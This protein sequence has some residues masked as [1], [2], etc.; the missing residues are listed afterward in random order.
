M[1]AARSQAVRLR[2]AR[3]A[4]GFDTAADAIERFGWKQSTYLAHE[5]GQNGIRPGPA[6]DYGKAYKVSSAWILTG[7]GRGPTLEAQVIEAPPTNPGIV[8]F[9][10]AAYTAIGRYDAAFSAGPG[11]LV[12]PNPVPL[13]YYL[14]ETQWLHA[15]T[16]AAPA[17]LAIVRVAGDSMVNTLHDG[18]WVLIDRTQRSISREGIYAIQVLD[19][20]WV[21]RLSL[22]LKEKLVRVIS[23]NPVVPMQELPEDELEIVGRVI[24][25]V[26][27]RMP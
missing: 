6:R 1:V 13:G 8:E 4:A 5:N 10:R 18:D 24:S 19:T 23:D 20:A 25:L 3:E 12:E 11:S 9:G 15:L 22:N 17:Q 7:E 2:Q 14:A 16:K 21:K 27:R 26:A